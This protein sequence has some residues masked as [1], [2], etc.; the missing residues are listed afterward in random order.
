MRTLWFS[1]FNLALS[2]TSA[3]ALQ[4]DACPGFAKAMAD[5][6]AANFPADEEQ[7]VHV[8]QK[9]I[10][11][12][13]FVTALQIYVPPGAEENG[14]APQP[15]LSFFSGKTQCEFVQQW[16]GEISEIIDAGNTRF[17]IA[18][19]EDNESDERHANFQVITVA[20][21][22]EVGATRDQ[23]GA[24]IYFSQS[25][26]NRC[27]GKI[28]D[29]TTWVRNREDHNLITLWQRH[30]DRDTKCRVTEESSSYRYYRLR[31][32]HWEIDEGEMGE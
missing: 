19:T 5:Y 14:T 4:A 22:G 17:V 12:T 24:E 25:T 16:D 32:D 18:K 7:P 26:Q 2:N 11:L 10:P 8:Q 9:V 1:L 13:P 3:P 15:F 23:H 27:E 31:A 21:T 30:T 28:G 29:V 20:P 6:M